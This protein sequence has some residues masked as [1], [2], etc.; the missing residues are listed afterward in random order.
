V[1]DIKNDIN[2]IPKLKQAFQQL[3]SR[4]VPVEQLAI[5]LVLRKNPKDYTQIC[6]QSSLGSRLG[7]HKDDTLVYYKCDKQELIHDPVRNKDV[8][9]MVHESDNAADISYA[10]YKD[11][12]VKSVKDVLDILGY[13]IEKELLS[14]RQLIHSGYIRRRMN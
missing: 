4:Q 14:K 7:L 6:K 3:D 10:E 13:D 2:P 1:H 5:S 8:L 11:I 12:L 9:R